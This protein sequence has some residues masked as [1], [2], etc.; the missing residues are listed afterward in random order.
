MVDEP[1]SCD[2]LSAYLGGWHVYKEAS[3]PNSRDG[4]ILVDNDEYTINVDTS[5]IDYIIPRT[6]RTLQLRVQPSTDAQSKVESVI[7]QSYEARFKPEI[8]QNLSIVSDQVDHR[9]KKLNTPQNIAASSIDNLE[10]SWDSV[11]GADYYEVKVSSL[12]NFGD[13][14]MRVITENTRLEENDITALATL[15]IFLRQS[16]SL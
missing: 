4:M 6:L 15:G 2:A 7:R 3:D 14:Y 5:M 16:Y 10:I 13:T 11:D 9:P 1:A 12:P 8:Y